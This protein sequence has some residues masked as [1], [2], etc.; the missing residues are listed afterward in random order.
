MPQA[1]KGETFDLVLF[2]G[3]LYHLR[4]PVLAL[5]CVRA[6]A[7]ERVMVETAI[8]DVELDP[9]LRDAALARFYRR[10]ELGADPTNWFAPTQRLLADWCE[11]SGLE[12]QTSSSWPAGA[13]SRGHTACRVTSGVPEAHRIC[14]E[15]VVHARVEPT[16]TP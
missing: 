13:P 11:S 16:W 5:D 1:L 3:V 12:V 14:F 8:C 7:R 15:G 4:H 9:A 2:W 10:D 6:V